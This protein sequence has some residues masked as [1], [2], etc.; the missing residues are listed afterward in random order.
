MVPVKRTRR[1]LV[2]LI[3]SCA[4]KG[5]GDDKTVR[6]SKD[7]VDTGTSDPVE[8][9]CADG[10]WG[11]L[12]DPTT[13]WDGSGDL[14]GDPETAIHVRTDGDDGDEGTLDA[15]VASLDVAV[16]L[17]RGRDSDK[18]IFVGPGTYEDVALSLS[19][20]PG[21]EATDDGLV[22]AGCRDEVTLTAPDDDSTILRVSE[23]E[24]VRLYDL[25]LEGGSRALWI[26]SGASVSMA[27]MKV[28]HSG[29]IGVVMDGVDTVVDATK[30]I[31]GDTE[32]RPDHP[33]VAIG[34]GILHA[35]VRWSGGGVSGSRQ[36]GIFMQGDARYGTLELQDLTVE[37]TTAD[38]DGLYGRGM[39]VQNAVTLSMSGVT[40]SDSADAGLY[41]LQTQLTTLDGL[42][43]SG[44]SAGEIPAESDTSGDAVVV[45]SDDGS[46]TSLDPAGYVVTMTDGTLADYAR[47]GALLEGVTATLEGNT[48]VGDEWI[49]S[50]GDADV[51]GTDYDNFKNDT[52]TSPLSLNRDALDAG[53]VEGD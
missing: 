47:A 23:A 44:V 53:V 7:S 48:G 4:C 14:V 16:T 49:V 28:N 22:L 2:L 41:I 37:D 18:V 19:Q 17:S 42:E 1:V 50:Q 6:D 11:A 10:T 3:W 9:P 27:R 33:G 15:P 31:I 24:D 29:T 40:I 21:H 38:D 5:G 52:L 8:S 34:A 12:T 32:D 26:W 43:V 45:T 51:S 46:G 13:D 20:D 30:L 36:A 39:Q 25:A 35:Q